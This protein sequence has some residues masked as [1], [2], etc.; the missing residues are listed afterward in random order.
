MNYDDYKTKLPYPNKRDHVLFR[1]H[2]KQ[3]GSIVS[4]GIT[5]HKASTI[6]ND[7]QKVSKIISKALQSKESEQGDIVGDYMV[8]ANF[9]KDGYNV[10]MKAYR[11]DERELRQKF[12]DDLAEMHGIAPRSE[13]HRVIYAKAWEDGHSCGFHEVANHYDELADFAEDVYKVYDE[14]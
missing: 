13:L 9:D 3:S 6:L 10:A 2:D 7:S 11:D 4:S 8:I 12:E 14:Q 5:P 1:I